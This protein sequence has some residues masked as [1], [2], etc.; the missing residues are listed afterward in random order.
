MKWQMIDFDYVECIWIETINLQINKSGGHFH[1]SQG[2]SN[3]LF[4]C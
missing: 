3:G 1:K 4:F 2:K